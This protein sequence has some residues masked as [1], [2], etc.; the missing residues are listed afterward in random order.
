MSAVVAPALEPLCLLASG[1]ALKSPVSACSRQAVAPREPV[2]QA[3]S[4]VK[5]RDL[6]PL[7]AGSLT[8]PLRRKP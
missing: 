3:S 5:Q 4:R 7:T 2:V 6:F 1:L 8:L